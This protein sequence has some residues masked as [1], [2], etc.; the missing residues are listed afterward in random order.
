[1]PPSVASA[2]DRRGPVGPA[3]EKTRGDLRARARSWVKGRK[4]TFRF[5]LNRPSAQGPSF[6][7]S[8]TFLGGILSC[9]LSETT[10]GPNK[11]KAGGGVFSFFK[12]PTTI[13]L[14]SPLADWRPWTSQRAKKTNDTTEQAHRSLR[15]KSFI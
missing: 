11:S 7:S 9:R 14:D 13:S 1:L 4:R 12:P 15:C 5:E 8:T 6:S 3:R 10:T 2:G